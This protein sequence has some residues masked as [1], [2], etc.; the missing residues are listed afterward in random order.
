MQRLPG[1]TNNPDTGSESDF[2]PPM[3]VKHSTQ[4]HHLRNTVTRAALQNCR[5]MLKAQKDHWSP[6]VA[7]VE[8]KSVFSNRGDKNEYLKDKRA[9]AVYCLVVPKRSDKT[10]CI[11]QRKSP[12]PRYPCPHAN[13]SEQKLTSQMHQDIKNNMWGHFI[14]GRIPTQLFSF[15]PEIHTA[16]KSTQQSSNGNLLCSDLVYFYVPSLLFFV[17]FFFFLSRAV[18]K[19][20]CVKNVSPCHFFFY[21]KQT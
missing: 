9:Y 2:N 14:W 1:K 13:V 10:H 17:L 21:I 12:P 5:L 4:W 8:L 3:S 18:W 7:G 16:D 6:V 19:L 20:I 15:L 11:K